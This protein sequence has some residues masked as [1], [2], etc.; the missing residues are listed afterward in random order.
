MRA[1]AE[2]VEALT[3][4]GQLVLETPQA[5]EVIDTWSGAGRMDMRKSPLNSNAILGLVLIQSAG[6]SH[7]HSAR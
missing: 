5:G 2:G 3:G 4:T 1:T 7:E 6:V